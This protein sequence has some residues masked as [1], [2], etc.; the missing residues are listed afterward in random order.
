MVGTGVVASDL[1]LQSHVKIGPES[2]EDPASYFWITE[3]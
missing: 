3:D 1:G 2:L